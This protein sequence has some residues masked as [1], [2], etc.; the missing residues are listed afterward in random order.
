M[1]FPPCRFELVQG[2]NLVAQPFDFVGEFLIQG[3]C[4]LIGLNRLSNGDCTPKSLIK[5]FVT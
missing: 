3:F 2:F 1:S 4:Y 5:I